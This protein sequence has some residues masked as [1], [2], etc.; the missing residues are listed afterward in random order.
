MDNPIAVDWSTTVV[1]IPMHGLASTCGPGQRT[2]DT[3]AA[4]CCHDADVVDT[5]R[6]SPLRIAIQVA[7]ASPFPGGPVNR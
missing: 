3:S 4:R 2:A 5:A 7:A 6:R 1:R